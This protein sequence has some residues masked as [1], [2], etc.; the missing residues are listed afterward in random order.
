MTVSLKHKFTSAKSDGADTSVVRPSNW[1][2]EHDLTLA[3]SKLLGRA[4]ASSGAAEEVSVGSSLVL[5]PATQTLKRAALTG[6]VTASEDSNTTS[7]ASGAVTTAKIADLN[8]TTGK[9]AD[10]GVTTGKIA[11]LG[12]TTGKINDLAV[13][14]GKLASGAATLAKLDTTGT[15]NYVLTAQG[16]GSA[17]VWAAA[18]GGGGMT[19]LGTITT[20]SG[21]SQSISSLTLTDYKLV[22]LVFQGVSFNVSP[23]ANSYFLLGQSTSDDL[24]ITGN[25]D[26]ADYIFGIA[27]IDL[28]NGTF[29]FS[30]HNSTLTSNTSSGTTG[31]TYSGDLPITTAST[32]ISIATNVGTFDAGSIRVYGIK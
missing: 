10:L 4:T 18:S 9:I 32:S 11:D 15:L 6:D 3:A 7:I 22:M 27:T 12:V 24:Q 5:D 23:S 1:N 31:D 26:R 2:D 28:T 17:P 21:A 13:T 20:T 25:I 30:Y 8:V 19:L 29:T 14:S 16:S